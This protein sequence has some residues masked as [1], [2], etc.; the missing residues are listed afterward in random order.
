MPSGGRAKSRITVSGTFCVIALL[1]KVVVVISR[2][3]IL[4]FGDGTGGENG[5]GEEKQSRDREG[6][7]GRAAP[8][9]QA[10]AGGEKGNAADADTPPA[11]EARRVSPV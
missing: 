10:G 5:E 3:R 7:N 11:D 8:I 6:G 1:R 4:T 9:L 2:G